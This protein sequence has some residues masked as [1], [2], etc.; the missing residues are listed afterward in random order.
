M[1]S[2]RSKIAQI[3]TSAATAEE[4]RSHYDSLSFWYRVFWGE[5]LHHGWF[6]TGR[7]KGRHAQIEMLRQCV[8]LLR[9]P[10]ASRVLDVGCG[11]G[12]TGIF[13]A[14]ELA[15]EVDCLNIS[16]NQ[17]MVA[18]KKIANAKLSAKVHLHLKDAESFT[19][20]ANY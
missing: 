10:I 20:P 15:C 19:Y 9:M 16:A 13:L 2:T 6:H 8:S 18:K 5:H 11:Y 14:S 7:E 12:A 1:M 4:I 17:L 3:T